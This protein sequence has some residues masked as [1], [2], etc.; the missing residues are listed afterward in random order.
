VEH[1]RSGCP[2]YASRPG[3]MHDGWVDVRV[4]VVEDCPNESKATALVRQAL[5]DVG[6]DQVPVHTER[7]SDLDQA[8]DGGFTGSPTILIDGQDPF[9]ERGRPA[10][11]ACR[12]Y[13]TP[14]AVRGVPEI[15]PLRE[16]LTEAAR[17][18]HR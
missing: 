18:A 4:V 1:E 3:R 10:A 15:G 17:R 6:M 9:A 7:V 16:A 12:L 2:L 13:G 14:A 11:M 5:A 8:R